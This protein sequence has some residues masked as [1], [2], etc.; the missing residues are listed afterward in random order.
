MKI[1]IVP[2]TT[3]KKSETNRLRREGNIPA[4]IY[5]KAKLCET[6]SL[7]RSDF[8]EKM[9][10]VVPGRLSTTIFLLVDGKGKERRAIIKEIQYNVTNYDVLHLDFEEMHD[11]VQLNIKVPIEFSGAADCPGVKLGGVL[12]QVIRHLRVRCLPRDVPTTFVMNVQDMQL[13]A[14]KRLSEIE[15]PENVRPLA[16]L[17]EV[18]V[19]IVKR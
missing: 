9:R 14:S 4:V 18:A 19:V 2:R 13:G 8:S 10:K 15:M 17:N 16:N 6:V 1:Q 5:T 7:K 12:R 11:D 3:E